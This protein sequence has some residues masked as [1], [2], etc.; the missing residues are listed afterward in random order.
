MTEACAHF[1]FSD[2][3][4]EDE[5]YHYA[6]TE[7]TADNAAKYHDHDYHE[8]FWLAEGRGRHEWNG[9]AEKIERGWLY[10][11]R[12]SDRHRVSGSDESPLQIV[13]LAFPSES[14]EAIRNRYYAREAD[15]FERSEEERKW[16]LG[17]RAWQVLDYWSKRLSEPTRPRVAVE[18]FLM[19]LP[20]LVSE[21]QTDRKELGMPDWLAHARRE[22]GKLEN[23]SGGTEA[24]AKLAGRS[25]SHV[26]RATVR[27]LGCTPTE[28]I[29]A[30]RIDYAS[31]QLAETNRPILDIMFDCG[32]TN[33]SH[34]YALFRKR[35]GVSPRRYRLQ[36]HPTVRG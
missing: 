10:L 1:K 35:H 29:N 17:P 24:F 18:G 3:V 7:L 4:R 14:W 20:L 2:F 23:F 26:S 27:W 34:F 21:D 33:L 16:R 6:S 30:A 9:R 36:A 22:I 31:Q 28:L 5:A 19:E 25:P 15:W 13:N 12:P 8:V 11:I 32:L